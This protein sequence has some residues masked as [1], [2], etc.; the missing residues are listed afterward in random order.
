MTTG[1]LHHLDALLDIKEL[2]AVQWVCGAGREGYANWIDV[3]RKIQ[4]KGKGLQLIIDV[5]ELE[6]VF[7][8]LRPEG[9][10]F[11]NISGIKNKEDADSVIKR[12]EKW[13]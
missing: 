1:A 4:K 2:N 9:V 3:Y 10:W 12:I 6:L 11:S 5:S 7:E 8:T 13:K